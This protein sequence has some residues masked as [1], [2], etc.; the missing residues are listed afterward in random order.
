[1]TIRWLSQ[2]IMSRSFSAP[3]AGCFLG[4]ADAADEDA[5]AEPEAPAP[6]SGVLGAFKGE[7]G[8]GLDGEA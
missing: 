1:V 7:V 8:T 3:S 4:P 5:P 2:T 6:V